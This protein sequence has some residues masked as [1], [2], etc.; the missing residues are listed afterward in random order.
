MMNQEKIGRF[1]AACRKDLGLTQAALA[2]KLGITDRAVSKW[3]TGKNLPDTALMLELCDLLQINVNELLTGE[4]LVSED[5]QKKAEENLFRL[6]QQE[7]QNNQ[8]LLSLETVIGYV[9]SVSFLVLIFSASFAVTQMQWRIPMI[10]A[11]AVIFAVG[12]YHSLKLEQG[13]GYYE[14]PNCHKRYVPTMRAVFLAPH[15]GRSRRMR[16]PY[17]GRKGYHRKMLTR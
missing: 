13:A 1:I 15:I 14:C 7:R 9:S 8:K 10:A 12:M 16:C 17:C 11:G 6:L 2:E 5:Y 4:R 3:E